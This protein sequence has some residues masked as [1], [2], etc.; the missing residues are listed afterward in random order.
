MNNIPDISKIDIN[1]LADDRDAIKNQFGNIRPKSAKKRS[2]ITEI[3][4]RPKEDI[5]R[6][7]EKLSL[8]VDKARDDIMQ[9]LVSENVEGGTIISVSTYSG[10]TKEDGNKEII[11][12]LS[13]NLPVSLV[14]IMC[15]TI[16]EKAKEFAQTM[17]NHYLEPAY[18]DG[19]V[20]ALI[21]KNPSAAITMILKLATDSAGTERILV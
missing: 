2:Q 11:T 21:K 4:A 12:N 1:A 8:L 10:N 15:D 13:M 9:F 16:S 17:I 3:S 14:A 18:E 5:A 19:R 20:K 7:N 6:F